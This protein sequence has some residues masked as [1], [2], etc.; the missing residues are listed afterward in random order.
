MGFSHLWKGDRLWVSHIRKILFQAEKIAS[1]MI[2]EGRMNGYVDQIDSI[3]HFEGNCLLI[4]SECSPIN[5]Y[6]MSFVYF[7][8]LLA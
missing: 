8:M 7:S 5:C 2:T 3:V 6:K 1:Q 4:L